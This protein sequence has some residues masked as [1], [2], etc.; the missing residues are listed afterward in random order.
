MTIQAWLG[1][2]MLTD[3]EDGIRRFT[4]TTSDWGDIQVLRPLPD[5]IGPWGVLHV[6][7]GTPYEDLIPVV[8]GGDLS[9]ALHG[10][11]TPLMRSIG[12]PPERLLKMIPE[13]LRTC[14]LSGTCIMYNNR[15]CLPG[16]KT[17]EC[18]EA[19]L[20]DAASMVASV[21]VQAWKNGR[22]VLVTEGDEFSL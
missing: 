20:D 10:H 14:R 8:S 4:L 13:A 19:P 5:E 17:P 11:G 22:Y 9:L 3:L 6:L 21:V 16:P 18:Y 2:S 1:C 12:R 15:V 7:K